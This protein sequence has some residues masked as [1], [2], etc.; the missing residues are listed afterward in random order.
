MLWPQ[1]RFVKTFAG[2]SAA[3]TCHAFKIHVIRSMYK[4]DRMG[5]GPKIVL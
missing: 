1:V 3:A 2:P 4:I 5:G